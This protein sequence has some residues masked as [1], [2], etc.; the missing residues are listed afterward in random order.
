MTYKIN[1]TEI[2]IQPTNGKWMPREPLDYSG[3]GHAIYPALRKFE[4]HWQL[5]DDTTVGQLQD[6][7]DAVGQTGTVVVDLPEY[8]ASTY[9]FFAYS[10]CILEEPKFGDYF[11]EHS[12]DVFL[13]VRNIRT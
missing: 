12:K 2:F 9:A 5:L 3:N 10:G 13:T 11:V 8:G 6:F 4:I 7:F 1:G